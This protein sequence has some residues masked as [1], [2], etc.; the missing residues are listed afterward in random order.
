MDKEETIQTESD[1]S[2]IYIIGAI[3]IVAVIVAGVLLWPKPKA[4]ESAITIPVVEQKQAITKLSC[5]SQWY[6]PRNWYAEYYL[7]A[8]GSALSTAKTVDC[9]FT[10]TSNLDGKV[11]ATEKVP[12]VLTA[13]PERGGQTYRC[14][15][16]ALPLPKGTAVTMKTMTSDDLEATAACK[17][18]SIVLP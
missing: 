10:V 13:A 7:S 12:A 17:A 18:G 8:E 1:S 15:T 6:N 4:K 14:T 3:I 5:D 9:T 16:K 2:I 11:V